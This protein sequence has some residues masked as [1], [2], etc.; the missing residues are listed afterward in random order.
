MPGY[1]C[2]IGTP[3][4]YYKCNLDA[5]SGKL[6]L[7][8]P[9]GEDKPVQSVHAPAPA[10]QPL[11]YSRAVPCT[12]RARA[13][14]RISESLMEAGADFLDGITLHPEGVDIHIAPAADRSEIIIEASRADGPGA[15]YLDNAYARWIQS[16]EQR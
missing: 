14:R 15:R 12:S 4:A 5:I 16:P 3:Q 6:H 2:D 1:W 7:P 11:P 8:Q 13:M 10:R 9:W